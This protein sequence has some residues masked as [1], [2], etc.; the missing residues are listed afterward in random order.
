MNEFYA[1]EIV[2]QLAAIPIPMSHI[3]LYYCLHKCTHILIT[4]NNGVLSQLTSFVRRKCSLCTSTLLPV[5]YAVL[6]NL[7]NLLRPNL[8]HFAP[9]ICRVCLLQTKYNRGTKSSSVLFC[10]K[11]Y[12]ILGNW[13][14]KKAKK[15]FTLLTCQ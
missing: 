8:F 15:N 12:V 10:N 11:F 2:W 5:F 6:C 9:G 3:D 4:R 7:A 1:D 14:R 13:F